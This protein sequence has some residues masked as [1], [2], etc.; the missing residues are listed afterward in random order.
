MYPP[1][2]AKQAAVAAA[3]RQAAAH[4]AE[5]AGVGPLSPNAFVDPDSTI[6]SVGVS[7]AK[8]LAAEAEQASWVDDNSW[9]AARSVANRI[10]TGA[11]RGNSAESS[12]ETEARLR[13]T[14]RWR[15]GA[16]TPASRAAA[17]A[18]RRAARA[19]ERELAKKNA[20]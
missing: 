11:V 7:G 1:P 19:K 2:S 8:R 4:R 9:W 5:R 6:R 13:V 16:A 12:G 3:V 20:K 17:L 15:P 10:A 18:K 14:L